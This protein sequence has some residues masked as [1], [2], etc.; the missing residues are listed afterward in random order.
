MGPKMSK[1]QCVVVTLVTLFLFGLAGQARAVIPQTMNFQGYLTNTA[2][3]PI[4]GTVAMVLSIYIQECGGDGPVD[5]VPPRCSA[6]IR[7][8]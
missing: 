5:G 6:A 3:T 1:V 4:T 2:G 8:L 7:R